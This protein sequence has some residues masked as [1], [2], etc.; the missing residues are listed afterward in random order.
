[1]ESL[2]NVVAILRFEGRQDLS[3]LL[4]DA[5]VDF[6]YLEMLFSMTSDAIIELTNANIYAPISACKTLRELFE[7]DGDIVLNALRE[8]WPVTQAGGTVIQSVSYSIDRDSLS[9]GT[10]RLY[11]NPIGWKRV[12]RTM[13]R[14][15]DFLVIASTEEQFEEL[16]VLC[17]DV[18][19]SV[20][21]VVFDPRLHPALPNDDTDVSETDV[22]RMLARYVASECP[23]PSNQEV[24]KCVNSSVDL[25]NKVT[26]SRTS[27]YRD[28][29]FCVQA[30]VN[31]IG[32][33]AIISGKRDRE[34]LR[35]SAESDSPEHDGI[36]DLPF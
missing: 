20:A 14:I 17:R 5:H 32:L 35:L 18:L 25:A 1:M 21:Q 16:G 31:V 26:H 10:T 11:T 4:A 27:V 24:R 15:R 29:A 3:A 7:E 6:E 23:G 34:E 22:K 19:I 36:A 8:V 9:D 33:I 30:T 12:D 28:A 2:E 13:D